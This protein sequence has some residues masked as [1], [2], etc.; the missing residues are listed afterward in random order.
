MKEKKFL[1]LIAVI[2]LGLILAPLSAQAEK[3]RVLRMGHF[4]FEKPG[5]IGSV[6]DLFFADEVYKRT[7]GQV[8]V[9]IYWANTIAQTKELLDLVRSGSIEMAAFPCGYFPSQFPLWRAPN[10]IPFVMTTVDEAWHTAT[11]LPN[12]IPA[13]REEIK[14]NNI[15]LLFHH[16]LACYELFSSKPVVKIEDFKGLRVRTWGDHLP[17]AFNAAGAVG[18]S[19][20]PAETYESL[21]RGVLDGAIW[22]LN[23]GYNLRMPE[24][25]PHVCLWHIMSIVGWGIFINLDVWN[26]LPADVQKVMQEVSEEALKV[27]YDRAVTWEKKAKELLVEKGATIHDIPDT[28]RQKWIAALPNFLDEWVDNME[29]LGKG[30]A[31]RELKKRWLEIVEKY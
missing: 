10:T 16:A 13:I 12:E 6:T 9:E 31:A 5:S 7:N 21:K 4:I 18:V 1:V 14:S 29:K 28:E 24:V 3:T 19:I 27:E 30:D 8:K 15:K 20:Y 17:R 22:G 25:A 11:K 23:N 26:Q 2:C